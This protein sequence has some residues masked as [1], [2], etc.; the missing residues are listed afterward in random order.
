M[1][2]KMAFEF[3]VDFFKDRYFGELKPNVEEN[4]MFYEKQLEIDGDAVVYK[5]N[6]KGFR[7]DDFTKDIDGMHI[8][9]GG[10]SETEGAANLLE[11]T[12]ANIL[13]N[14]IKESND[15]AGY[16]NVG[17]AGLT[18]STVI[19]NVFQYIYE[20]GCPD[21]IFLYL[22]DQAR[23]I[24]WS[25]DRGFYPTYE[26]RGIDIG[27]IEWKKFFNQ[28]RGPEAVNINIL[29][30][31]FL[32]KILNQFCETNNIK[33]FWSTWHEP[34]SLPDIVGEDLFAGYVPTFPLTKE[35]W[36]IK[37][38][39]LKARDGYHYGKGFHNVWAEKFYEVFLNDKNNK[40]NNH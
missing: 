8:L 40:T 6:N 11:D 39:D 1:S 16:Y 19:M 15:V 12:W 29:Y 35:Y 36:N 33:L 25:E 20:Y 27:E 13:Y 5:Y 31:H 10:C 2:L 26:S 7:C 23:H 22:P 17:K 32:F 24:T 9:F 14:K 30:T 21:Y 37:I 34:S 38:K 18:T 4:I 28:T 3:N